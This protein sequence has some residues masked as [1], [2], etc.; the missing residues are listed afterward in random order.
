MIRHL[1]ALGSSFAAGPGIE[2]VADRLAMRSA[3]NYAHI[4][5][6]RLGLRL[7]DLTVSGATTTSAIGDAVGAAYTA[8]GRRVMLPDAPPV[9][10][11]PAVTSVI[12]AVRR[13]PTPA[14]RRGPVG[15]CTAARY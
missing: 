7:T 3:R 14:S 5:A 12:E 9:V 15:S 2:P 6:A 11:R 1:A 10:P 4:V 8:A 13:E